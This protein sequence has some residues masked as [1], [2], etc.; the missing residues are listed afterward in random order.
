MN[1]LGGAPTV[2]PKRGGALAGADK[3]V[4]RLMLLIISAFGL[5][6]ILP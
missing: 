1:A 2:V 5:V 3:S 6:G 4:R